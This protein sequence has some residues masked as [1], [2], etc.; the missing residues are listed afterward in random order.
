MGPC[1]NCSRHVSLSE[2]VCPFCGTEFGMTRRALVGLAAA[3]A[4]L[5]I[6]PD[7]HSRVQDVQPEY[8]VDRPEPEKDGPDAITLLY[9]GWLAEIG[10][11]NPANSWATRKPGTRVHYACATLRRCN[12]TLDL[13]KVADGKISL[14]VTPAG[15]DK[16]ERILGRTDGIPKEAKLLDETKETLAIDGT[17]YA[18]A[19]KSYEMPGRTF[20]VW[21]CADAPF[22]FAKVESG[23]ETVILVKA[24]EN[25]KTKAG[26]YE[27]SVWQST[28]GK[29]TTKMWRCDKVPGLAICVTQTI[30]DADTTTVELEYFQEGK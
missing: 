15:G 6:V 1:P 24:K 25:R 5:A 20:K 21:S 2:R 7:A 26:D 10:L 29:T 30:K 3:A 13:A 27:C 23:D 12:V 22:G 16:K 9:P 8:G 4:T 17:N 28:V 18:C 11:L 19:V 14:T